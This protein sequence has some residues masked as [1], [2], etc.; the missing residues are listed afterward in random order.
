VKETIK[1]IKSK[2]GFR[3]NNELCQFLDISDKTLYRIIEKKSQSKQGRSR[4]QSRL[5]KLLDL[6]LAELNQRQIK[7]I[8]KKMRE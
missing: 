6:C 4:Y 2:L 8:L 3:F 7:R 1:R 5:Y